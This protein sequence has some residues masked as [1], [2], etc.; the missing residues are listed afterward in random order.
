MN[1]VVCSFLPIYQI[2]VLQQAFRKKFEGADY[3][4]PL[5]G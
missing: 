3:L 2:C 5:A 1:L 4:A